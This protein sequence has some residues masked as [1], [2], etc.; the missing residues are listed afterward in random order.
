MPDECREWFHK[1][2]THFVLKQN[3]KITHCFHFVREVGYDSWK[4][5]MPISEMTNLLPAVVNEF[6]YPLARVL[7]AFQRST[8]LGSRGPDGVM[9]FRD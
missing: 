8:S 4:R 2:R 9:F 5:V 1:D 7:E 3:G 6:E